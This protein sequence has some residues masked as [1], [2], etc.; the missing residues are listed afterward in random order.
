MAV[1]G[2]SEQ[3]VTWHTAETRV[4]R[5][6][7]EHAIYDHRSCTIKRSTVRRNPVDGRKDMPR[8]EVP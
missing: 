6:N 1:Y 3:D 4:A 5:I 2:E 8:I 7:V